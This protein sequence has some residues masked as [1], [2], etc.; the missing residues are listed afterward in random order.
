MD[1]E[2]SS[3]AA[4]RKDK[5]RKKRKKSGGAPLDP[6]ASLGRWQQGEQAVDGVGFI[7]ACISPVSL[8]LGRW[9]L[10][11]PCVVLIT[12]RRAFRS[13]A[14]HIQYQILK[15][16]MLSHSHQYCN[17]YSTK[18]V[19]AL[20]DPDLLHIPGLKG[21]VNSGSWFKES[22]SLWIFGFCPTSQLGLQGSHVVSAVSVSSW[23]L[24]MAVT[25]PA[26]C[27][28]CLWPLAGLNLAGGLWWWSPLLNWTK[29]ETW[30]R[31]CWTSSSCWTFLLLL[32][33]LTLCFACVLF[34]PV[35]DP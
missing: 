28:R 6:S 25:P 4:W 15:L 10:L 30:T 24:W 14:V 2:F 20:E 16:W 19:G 7:C 32:L 22:T 35:F 33:F 31:F 18:T 34:E 3:I 12:N 21:R 9:M 13:W 29:P 17:V 8:L 11:M 23:S 27:P 5:K 26:A 1:D